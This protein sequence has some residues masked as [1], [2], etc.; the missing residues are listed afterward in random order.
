MTQVDFHFNVPDVGQ[1]ACRLVRKAWHAGHRV[2][3]YCE[4]TR[5][6]ARF[7][8]QLWDFQPLAFVP[9]VSVRHPL[10]ARNPIVFYS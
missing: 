8:R 10:A 2:V 6:L 3:V 5:R 1:Y 4:D 7:D 9:H